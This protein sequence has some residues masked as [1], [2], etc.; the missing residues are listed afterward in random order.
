MIKL[1]NI[2]EKQL[3]FIINEIAN[4]FFDYEYSP[5][6]CGLVKFIS[7]R[8][9]MYI[10][11]SAITRAA[12]KAGLL[13]STSEKNEGFLI[14][15]GKEMGT[16]KFWDGIKM[17]NAEKKALGGI[18]NLVAFIKLCFSDGGTI[19]TR[20]KKANRSFIRIEMLVVRKEFQKQ[21]FMKQM[22]NYAYTLSDE[23]KVPV[24]LDT[25]DL[26]KAER[27]EHLGM[28][29]DRKRNCNDSLHLYDLIYNG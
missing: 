24:I 25:D 8:E 19:E 20:M 7:T 23:Y 12:Y 2:T 28:K 15:S 29:L 22:L 26:N 18:K 17:I 5:N 6:D 10:Y 11:M 27:Y 16:I 4:A 9:D 14:L 1:Q 13:Y 21:G 3:D